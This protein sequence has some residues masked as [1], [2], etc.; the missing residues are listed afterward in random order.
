MFKLLSCSLLELWLNTPEV[1]VVGS[2]DTDNMYYFFVVAM[3]KF[4]V[5]VGDQEGKKL[6]QKL[7]K[8]RLAIYK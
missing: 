5:I 3:F 4:S 1:P 7:F 2:S 8:V 6:M